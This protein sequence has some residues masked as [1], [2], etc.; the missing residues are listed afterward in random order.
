MVNIIKG[1][2][3]R[4]CLNKEFGRACYAEIIIGPSCG[5]AFFNYYLSFERRETLFIFYIPAK[6]LK[7]RVNEVLSYL[8]LNIIFGEIV[9]L[10]LFKLLDK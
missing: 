5:F 4:L 1:Y 10:V 6:R 8:R 3:G 9:L 2:R 7:E